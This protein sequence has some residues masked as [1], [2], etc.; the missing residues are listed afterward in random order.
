MYDRA[1]KTR[2]EH[3]KAVDNWSDFMNAINS[4]DLCMTPWC[5]EAACE[6]NVKDRSKEESMKL[7]EQSGE[8]EVVLTGSAKTMCIPYEQEALKEG[9]KCFVCDKNATTRAL[10]GRTY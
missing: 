7:M 4:K 8:E 9:Q 1:L 5:N 2:D 6:V 10:W 3:V